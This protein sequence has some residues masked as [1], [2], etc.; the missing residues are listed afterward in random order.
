MLSEK[1]DCQLL[2]DPQLQCSEV[3][4]TVIDGLLIRAA[5]PAR[6]CG[7]SLQGKARAYSRTMVHPATGILV[8]LSMVSAPLQLP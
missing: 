5:P 3:T 6:S 8:S 1:Q 7:S 4:L 2:A